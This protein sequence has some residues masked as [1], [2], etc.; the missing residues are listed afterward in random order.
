MKA[1]ADP[2]IKA[3]KEKLKPKT[4]KSKGSEKEGK[5]E[6]HNELTIYKLTPSNIISEIKNNF[7]K[8]TSENSDENNIINDIKIYL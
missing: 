5:E 8:T 6:K 3:D 1:N 2:N 4:K 7:Y